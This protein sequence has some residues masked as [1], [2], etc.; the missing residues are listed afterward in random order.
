MVSAIALTPTA[1]SAQDSPAGADETE[2]VVTAQ[3]QEEKSVDVPITIATLS[4]GPVALRQCQRAV[5]H[6]ET[7][8]WLALRHTGTRDAADYSRRRHGNHDSGGG[9]NVAIYVDGFFLPNTY[10]SDLQLM[11]VQNIQVLKGPQGTLFGRNTTGGAI[12]VTSA[13]PGTETSA[14]FRGRP[15]AGST[16]RRYRPMP[17]PASATGSLSTSK[18]STAVATAISPRA[19]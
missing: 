13:D 7:N 17:L 1:A 9:P 2:I 18:A 6:V 3:R 16:P 8:A 10:T 4:S 19:E 15:T 11:R 14:E 12:L 5:R